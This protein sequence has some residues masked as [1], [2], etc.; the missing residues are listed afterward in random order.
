MLFFCKLS[1]RLLSLLGEVGRRK[2]LFFFFFAYFFPIFLPY[3]LLPCYVRSKIK[4]SL[5]NVSFAFVLFCLKHCWSSV[6]A[7]VV[8]PQVCNLH[9]PCFVLFCFV[10]AIAWKILTNR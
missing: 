6:V 4:R 9:C 5:L 8:L 10:F 3:N 7:S 2:T 1:E